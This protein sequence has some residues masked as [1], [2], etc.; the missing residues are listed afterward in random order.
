MAMEADE[1]GA[2][3]P[4]SRA[5]GMQVEGPL[6]FLYTNGMNVTFG[7]F[8]FWFNVN[9]TAPGGARAAVGHVAMSPQHAKLLSEVLALKVQEYEAAFGHLFTREEME[10]KVQTLNERMRGANDDEPIEPQQ[11]S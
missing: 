11:P 7:P 6:P 1:I 10:A 5:G 2:A 3:T 9:M 8:D 4:S